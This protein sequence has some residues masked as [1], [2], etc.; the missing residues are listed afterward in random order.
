MTPPTLPDYSGGSLVNL[1]AELERRLIGSSPSPPLHDALATLIPEASSYVLVLFDGL[2]SGQLEHPAA[3]SMAAAAL[4]HI[5]APFPTTTT[6]S[7]ATVATGLPPSQHGLIGYQMRLAELDAVVNT[8]KWTTLWGEPVAFD[9]S[10]LLPSPNLWER[11]AGKGAEPVTIQPAHFEGSPLTRLLYRG[12]RFDGVTTTDELVSA[13]AQLAAVPGRLIFT[14]VPHV[15]F[16]AH[17]Y[18]QKSPDYAGAVGLADTVWSALAARL[19]KGASLIG[20]A[21]HGHVDFPPHRQVKIERRDHESRDFSGDGRA[22]YVHG[23]GASLAETLPAAWYSRGDM[24]D[25]WGPGPEHPAI[26]G[27]AP[28]GV[29]L[30]DDD[31]LLL[32]KHSDDRMVGNHGGLTAAERRIPLLV[33]YRDGGRA[34]STSPPVAQEPKAV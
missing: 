16:A 13:T 6:V 31:H 15:D 19:P 24:R 11:L 2:G 3:H 20:T 25:W 34:E 9:T 1:V 5:D 14:Y 21:D 29:L 18:G 33:A 28:D 22:M 4:A 23:E 10:S 30:A 12:C 7:L 27:R 8:I 17:V 32:H 26:D